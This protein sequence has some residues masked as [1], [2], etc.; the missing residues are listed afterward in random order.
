MQIRNFWYNVRNIFVYVGF[1]AEPFTQF[2]RNEL[3]AGIV[4][5]FTFL[6]VI[7]IYVW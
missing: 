3:F 5:P 1:P 2:E 4:F 7:V 6:N